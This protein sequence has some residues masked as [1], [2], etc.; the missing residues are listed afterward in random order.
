MNIGIIL[1]AGQGKRLNCQ[2]KN[3]TSLE[4]M[5]KP[6]VEYGANLFARTLDKTIVVTGAF[7]DSVAAALTGYRGIVYVNQTERLGTGHAVKVA[8]DQ[9]TALG[10]KPDKVLVGYGDH[11]MFYKP[12]TVS[13]LMSDLNAHHCVI[14]LISTDLDDPD[15]YAWGRIIRD[16]QGKVS[17]IVEQKDANLEERKIRESNAGFYCFDYNFLKTYINTLAKSPVSGE[18]YITDLIEIAVIKNLG[19]WATKV[20]FDHVG[21]GINT[22]EQLEQ[23]KQ[24]FQTLT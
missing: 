13:A 8:V 16:P 17:R 10:L 12:A 18:Y 22:V 2:D 21:I 15:T 23:S 3:K 7:A 9:I 14:S 11:M 4:F 19:V 20:P 1:A 6:L 5:G 24:L